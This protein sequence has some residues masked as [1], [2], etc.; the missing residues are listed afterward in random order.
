MPE[1]HVIISVF[2]DLDIFIEKVL[3]WE[4]IYVVSVLSIGVNL[5]D[6]YSDEHERIASGVLDDTA[7]VEV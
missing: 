1:H 3:N 2:R 5:V 4:L 6:R 7:D